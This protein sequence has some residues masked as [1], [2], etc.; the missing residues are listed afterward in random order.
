M[1]ETPTTVPLEGRT[2]RRSRHLWRVVMVASAALL[3]AGFGWGG[4]VVAAAGA[5][6]VVASAVPLWVSE[7]RVARQIADDE[8][9]HRGLLS[10]PDPKG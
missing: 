3:F 2:R 9:F 10:R 8:N 6:G 4:W 7:R 5:L 1:S